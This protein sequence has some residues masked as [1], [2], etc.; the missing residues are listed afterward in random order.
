MRIFWVIFSFF[1]LFVKESIAIENIHLGAF[2]IKPSFTV[3][4]TYTD[5]IFP[6]DVK[7]VIM[8]D[9]NKKL[10]KDK[11]SATNIIL[12]PNLELSLP[13]RNNLFNIIYKGRLIRYQQEDL[14]RYNTDT[15]TINSK[16]QWHFLTGLST[17]IT[18]NLSYGENPPP[19]AW[20]IN[21]TWYNNNISILTSY[22]LGQK[23]K[24]EIE[25]L[26]SYRRYKEKEFIPDNHDD[27]LI[28]NTIL[29]QILPKTFL[30]FEY[31]YDRYK[32]EDLPVQ[33]TDY[34][35]QNYWFVIQFN[36]PNDRLNGSLRGGTTKVK[37]D[38]HTLNTGNNF[39]SFSAD[40]T[41]KKSRYTIINF[42]G[43]RSQS[44]TGVTTEDYQ[45]G[46][47]FKSTELTLTLNHKFTYKIS[48]E[49]SYSYGWTNFNT[50][51]AIYKAGLWEPITSARKDDIKKWSGKIEYQMR[52]WLGFKFNYTYTDHNSNYF[53]E[54][55]TKKLF[56]TEITFKF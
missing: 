31:S 44:T 27:F 48:G 28:R 47:S 1:Y 7:Q 23:Y 32:R 40:L 19:H 2:K 33:D 17:E 51:G 25:I 55:Y 49:L 21:R 24:T 14:E 54:S 41:F 42:S 29:Y 20:G 11:T 38:D 3:I 45:Y 36:N 12:F 46:S 9:G 35:S 16:L 6:R 26:K 39:F 30:G 37:Y 13:I 43:I 5:N 8:K 53:A 56:S 15:H 34:I 18:D 4:R 10:I 52:K 22:E 50:E